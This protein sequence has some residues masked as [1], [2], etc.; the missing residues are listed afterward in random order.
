MLSLEAS[1]EPASYTHGGIDER[2]ELDSSITDKFRVAFR[3]FFHPIG[4]IKVKAK[5]E[6]LVSLGSSIE[7]IEQYTSRAQQ[8]AWNDLVDK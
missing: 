1:V 8:D 5:D 3:D 6:R 7:K 4:Q 2:L